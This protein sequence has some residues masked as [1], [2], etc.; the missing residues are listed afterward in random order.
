[1][2]SLPS[3]GSLGSQPQSYFLSTSVT[4]VVIPYTRKYFFHTPVSLNS[5][6]WS[7]CCPPF[8]RP[9]KV[10][11]T[12]TV[13]KF[14]HINIQKDHT[15]D[16]KSYCVWVTV[17]NMCF[18]MGSSQLNH[19]GEVCFLHSPLPQFSPRCHSNPSAVLT[20]VWCK[21]SC[22]LIIRSKAHWS[23]EKYCNLCSHF[24]AQVPI[25]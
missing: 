1:M 10:R 19:S 6:P 17:W 4:L 23:P 12:G 22:H 25:P 15:V 13:S 8:R 24:S 3:V 18:L 20:R 16:W 14:Y 9:R 2:I 11:T 21:R 7:F 5:L